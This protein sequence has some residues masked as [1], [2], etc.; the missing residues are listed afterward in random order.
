MGEELTVETKHLSGSGVNGHI[1]IILK[2]IHHFVYRPNH[3][4]DYC[5]SI[6]SEDFHNR[7]LIAASQTIASGYMNIL[8]ST[9]RLI[10]AS[11][12]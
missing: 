5:R 6:R 12:L 1:E 2:D 10:K 3:R 4:F 8:Q 7:S 11:P 9:V